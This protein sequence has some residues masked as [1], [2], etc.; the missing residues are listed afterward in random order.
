MTPT[1]DGGLLIGQPCTDCAEPVTMV[2]ACRRCAREPED[3]KFH[4]CDAHQ[5]EAEER[6]WQIRGRPAD[7]RGIK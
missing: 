1:C 7:W 5:M 2:C 3:E 4:S 6:H